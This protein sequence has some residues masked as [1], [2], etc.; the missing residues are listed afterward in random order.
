M[1]THSHKKVVRVV[2]EIMSPTFL[3]EARDHIFL[4]VPLGIPSPTAYMSYPTQDLVNLKE[5]CHVFYLA[6]RSHAYES[7]GDNIIY[8]I[9]I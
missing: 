1:Y 6:S 4:S 2:L 7:V 8:C 9:L 5:T 3:S